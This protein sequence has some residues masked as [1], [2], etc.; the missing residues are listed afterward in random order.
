MSQN[1]KR[2]KWS[3]AEKLVGS[4]SRVFEN[5]KGKPRVQEQRREA[6]V[7]P[8]KN[9]IAEITVENLELKKGLSV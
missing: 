1:G 4:A 5:P 8:L 9:V 3:A 6:E 7:Q 2:R